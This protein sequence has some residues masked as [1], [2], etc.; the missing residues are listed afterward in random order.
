M[1]SQDVENFFEIFGKRPLTGKFSQL[2]YERI[3]RDT[4]RDVAF[5]FRYGKSPRFSADE[6]HLSYNVL[7]H[8]LYT[9]VLYDR[10]EMESIHCLVDKSLST[11]SLIHI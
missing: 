1:K 7:R 10:S 9:S 6:A 11:L 5:K 3:H 8:C 4:D 2:C